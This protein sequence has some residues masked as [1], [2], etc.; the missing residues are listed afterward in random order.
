MIRGVHG[1]TRLG[2]VSDLEN[3]DLSPSDWLHVLPLLETPLS[4]VF[5]CIHAFDVIFV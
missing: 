1:T 3:G 4:F 2:T 5:L